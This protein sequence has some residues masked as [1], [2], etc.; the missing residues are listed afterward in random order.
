MDPFVALAK[1]SG[2]P[3]GRVISH[4]PGSGFSATDLARH[5]GELKGIAPCVS[6]QSHS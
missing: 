3:T 6:Q 1:Q 5:F 2:D 4:T